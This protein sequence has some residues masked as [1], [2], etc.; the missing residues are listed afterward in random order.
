M[1]AKLLQSS[2]TLCNHTDCSPSDSSVHGIIQA[3][4]QEWVVMLSSRD[5]PN[6][7]LN[8]PLLHL[9]HWQ[10]SPSPLAPPEN[11]NLQQRPRKAADSRKQKDLSGQWY[12]LYTRHGRFRKINV[13]YWQ[14]QLINICSYRHIS[15]NGLAK[16]WKF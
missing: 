9:L 15:T 11:P 13:Q 7:G 6:P 1:H 2:P 12:S 10:V 8:L 5:L 3:R 4:I 14:L 16:L